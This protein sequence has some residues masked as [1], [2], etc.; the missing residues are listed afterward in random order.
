MQSNNQAN[1]T[2]QILLWDKTNTNA[3]FFH[4]LYLNIWRREAKHLIE[5]IGQVVKVE[6]IRGIECNLRIRE[7]NRGSEHMLSHLCSCR[8]DYVGVDLVLRGAWKPGICLVRQS[9]LATALVWIYFVW[10][11]TVEFTVGMSLCYGL[12]KITFR[13]LCILCW[14][15]FVIFNSLLSFLTWLEAALQQEPMRSCKY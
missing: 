8:V 3:L 1:Q 7:F 13:L 11:W 6:V 15:G 5:V 10:F 14:F 4:Q 12:E 2:K 9:N